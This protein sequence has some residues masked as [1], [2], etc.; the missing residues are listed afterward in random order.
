[1]RIGCGKLKVM[2]GYSPRERAIQDLYVIRSGTG[3]CEKNIQA[4]AIYMSG[5]LRLGGNL[6]MLEDAIDGVS[7]CTSFAVARSKNLDVSQGSTCPSAIL[8][9]LKKFEKNMGLSGHSEAIQKIDEEERKEKELVAES[10]KRKTIC[11]ECGVELEITG[12]CYTCRN[13]GYSKC[14]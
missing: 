3:G 5:I 8:N 6:F 14:E 2:I 4:V 1:M 11:P 7:G 9:V 10:E 13:C 12:G